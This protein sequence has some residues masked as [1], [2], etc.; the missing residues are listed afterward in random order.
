M[1][2]PRAALADAVELVV[3]ALREIRAHPLRSALTLSGIVFGAASLVSMTSMSKAMQSMAYRDLESIGFPHSYSIRDQGPR[4]DATRAGDLRHPGLR[5]ADVRALAAQPG[6]SSAHPRNY[7]GSQVVAGPAGRRSVT[8]DG[9]DADYLEQR[10]FRILQGRSLRALDIANVSRVVVV[11]EALV[12]DLFGAA[13]PVGRTITVDGAKFLVIGVVAPQR[14]EMAPINFDWVARRVYLPYSYL[15]R[16]AREPGHVDEV[17]LTARTDADLGNVIRTGDVQ[18]RQ[19]HQGVVDYEIDNEAAGVLKDRGMADRVLGGWNAVLY[20]ISI[21]TLLVGGIGL[22][23]VLL[24]SVRERV[25]EIGVRKALGADDGAIVRL[26]LAESLTLS[27]LGAVLGV[28]GGT[29]LIWITVAIGHKFGKEFLIPLYMPGAMLAI[30]FSLIVGVAF[31]WYP[32]KRAAR[33]DPIEAIRG[34]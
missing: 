32:A 20:A 23:S 17:L 15:T 1:A 29:G 21:V 14:F 7:G 28:L 16:Y 10:N 12:K 6:L 22:F 2:D 19:R 13:P 27:L 11:G 34:S 8:V 3:D 25:R 24:I 26:F 4:S 18:L 30:G 33:L 9:V 5:L 31:G